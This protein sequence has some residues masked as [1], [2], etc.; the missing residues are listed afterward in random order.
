MILLAR[1]L[2]MMAR[3]DWNVDTMFGKD[4][5]LCVLGTVLGRFRAIKALSIFL[6]IAFIYHSFLSL[7]LQELLLVL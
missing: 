1:L 3:V 5:L 2:V 7:L 4:T 6:K